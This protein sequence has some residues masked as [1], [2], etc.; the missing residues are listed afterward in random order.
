[1]MGHAAARNRTWSSGVECSPVEVFAMFSRQGVNKTFFPCATVTPLQQ[2][3]TASKHRSQLVS[4]F[5][6]LSSL[7]SGPANP[8][9]NA[10]SLCLR[11]PSCGDLIGADRSCTDT[12]PAIPGCFTVE[13]QPPTPLIRDRKRERIKRLSLP[14]IEPG[15]PHVSSVIPIG[16]FAMLSR[17]RLI[18]MFT[19]LHQTETS[20]P[21]DPVVWLGAWLHR[22]GK[23]QADYR[24]RFSYGIEAVWPRSQTSLPACSL[25]PALVPAGLFA[26]HNA[27]LRRSPAFRPPMLGRKCNRK[28]AFGDIGPARN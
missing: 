19:T 8:K 11:G 28:R 13:L 1:M 6:H 21:L 26:R 12:L 7:S 17:Q 27:L 10:W 25:S 4:W 24:L 3:V 18:E 15:A 23:A 5:S 20:V 22:S 9:I 14:G 2:N 16:V